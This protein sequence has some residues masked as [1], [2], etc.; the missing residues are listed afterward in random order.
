MNVP[1]DTEKINLEE[2]LMQV[3][4]EVKNTTLSTKICL[5]VL[6]LTSERSNL[7]KL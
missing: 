4:F 6:M 2:E 7:R 5:P 3:L 1:K